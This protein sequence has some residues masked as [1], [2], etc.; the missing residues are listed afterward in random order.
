MKRFE[1]FPFRSVADRVVS[2]QQGAGGRRS[3]HTRGETRSC[4]VICD[5]GERAAACISGAYARAALGRSLFRARSLLLSLSLS[6]SLVLS[7]CL[8]F[9]L[10][11]SLFLSLSLGGTACPPD[12]LVSNS[13]A[14]TRASVDEGCCRESM[15][16]IRQERLGSVLGS[17][18]KL[19][20]LFP[21]RW[22]AEWRRT[23]KCAAVPRRTR[24]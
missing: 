3:H 2:S 8:L 7:L 6:S 14:A 24:I 18:V 1:V 4:H 19:F 13:G 16:H 22:E 21:R 23:A 9:S 10:V 12:A 5:R 17:Q 15:A 20:K 11:L